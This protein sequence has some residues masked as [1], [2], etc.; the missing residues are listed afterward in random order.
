VPA[1]ALTDLSYA[2]AVR[3]LEVQERA[4]DQL[5]ARTGLLLAA[6]SLTASFLGAQTLQHANGIDTLEGLALVSLLISVGTCTY[7]LLPKKGFVFSLS[8]A[9]MY[10]ELFEFD[11]D[12]MRQRLI[13]W[14][15]AYW[16]GNQM[17]VES[18][19]RY[20]FAAA[21]AFLFQLILWS[22]ALTVTI[23]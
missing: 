3:A 6:T 16:Q 10:E 20:F 19:G 18:L 4:V 23:T 9:E 12:E 21:V 7:V 15:E 1:E 13:Y 14:L 22:W 11:D 17:S 5:R 8:G 2:A